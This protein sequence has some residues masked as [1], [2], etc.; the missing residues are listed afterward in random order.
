[1]CFGAPETLPMPTI[2]ARSLPRLVATLDPAALLGIEPQRHNPRCPISIRSPDRV[3]TTLL[4]DLSSKGV[5]RAQ[6]AI[7]AEGAA[8]VVLT[9]Q[10]TLNGAQIEQA[11]FVLMPVRRKPEPEVARV[12]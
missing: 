4:A 12:A 1:M 2:T 11:G 9:I 3:G 6:A 8:N 5:R 7:L 10:G